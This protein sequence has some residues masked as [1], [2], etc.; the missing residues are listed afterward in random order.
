MKNKKQVKVATEMV[1]LNN[2]HGEWMD[3]IYEKAAD[4]SEKLVAKESWKKN[5][6]VSK[7]G[8]LLAALMKN[9]AGIS[10]I[11]FHALGHG[12]ASWD[13]SV[14]SPGLTDT[15]LYDEY[16][17]KAPDSIQFLDAGDNPTATV[18]NKILITT[19]FDFGE[20]T[21]SVREQGL[22]GGNA[23]AG[24]DSGFMVDAIRHKEIYKDASRKIIR[25]IKLTFS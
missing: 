17:R 8:Q 10:G 20:A 14:P 7:L 13:I 3:E 16:Y 9:E 19:T 12:D 25:R 11:L 5:L 21:G 23:T 2:I 6:I 22:F 1:Q 18:A 24:L 4:G 15:T